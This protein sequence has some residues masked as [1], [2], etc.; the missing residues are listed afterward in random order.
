M[1]SLEAENARISYVG[2]ALSK[3]HAISWIAHIKVDLDDLVGRERYRLH[4][5]ISS[6][7][8]ISLC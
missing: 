2:V 1:L 6:L 4:L 3:E 5:K 8:G 7:L